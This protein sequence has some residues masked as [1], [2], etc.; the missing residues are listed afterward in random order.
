MKSASVRNVW[1]HLI[2]NDP[3]KI[4]NMN[5]CGLQYTV[6]NVRVILPIVKERLLNLVS[7]DF[8]CQRECRGFPTKLID[9]LTDNT[10][11]VGLSATDNK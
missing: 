10:V 11:L 4:K 3:M 2:K 6:D 9:F 7:K 5:L 8:E 1:N